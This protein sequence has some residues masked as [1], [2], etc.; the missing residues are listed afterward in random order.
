[1]KVDRLLGILTT[2]LQQGRVTA[3][4]LARR[5]EV[6]R[7]TIS[8]D[9]DALC[10]AG[11]P[12]VTMP[13][14]GGGIA[15]AEGYKL[16]KSVLTRDEL[17]NIIISLRGL[18]SVS[19]GTQIERT[20][21]KLGV[22]ADSAVVSLRE[23]TIIDL[24][25]NSRNTL[26]EKIERLRHAI[27]E[28]LVVQFDYYY[29]KGEARRRLEPCCLVFVWSAWYIFGYC[30]LREDF[31][32]FKLTRL[33]NLE[34]GPERFTPREVPPGRMDWGARFADDQPLVALFDPSQKHH[35]IDSYGLSCFDEAPDGRLRLSVG[36]TNRAYT[37]RWLLGFGSHVEVVEPAD[38]RDEI[39]AEA[40]KM[41]ARK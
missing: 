17:S 33:W 34:V 25:S 14:A 1:M 27:R 31:R 23:H 29:D 10:R 8:R 3:P 22:G 18:G 19:G 2:L 9:I 36:Y 41:L 21:D 24:S 26:A 28:G 7:R 12:V 6:S 35:L 15:I 32:M 39:R 11:I 38:L 16:D 37:L 13:G 4:M 5:F 40:E 20:L 30:P